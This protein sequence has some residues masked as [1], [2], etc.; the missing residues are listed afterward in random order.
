MQL[1]TT[2]ALIIRQEKKDNSE[3]LS[4]LLHSCQSTWLTKMSIIRQEE[5]DNG[6]GLPGLLLSHRR[7][8]LENGAK[9]QRPPHTCRD[10]CYNATSLRPLSY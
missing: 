4:R 1:L 10:E 3:G 9:K 7:V 5:K 6:K 2:I 8:A